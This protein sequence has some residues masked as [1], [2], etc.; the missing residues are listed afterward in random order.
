MPVLNEQN[1]IVGI[2]SLG[3][4]SKGEPSHGGR[5]LKGISKTAIGGAHHA[6]N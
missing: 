2:V 6:P 5:A 4:I 3:D 1:R